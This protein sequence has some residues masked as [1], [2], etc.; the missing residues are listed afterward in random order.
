LLDQNR[1]ITPHPAF[2]LFAT[3]NTIGLG[4]TSGLYHGTQQI[5][6]GQMDRWSIVTTLNYLPHDKEAGI[7]L[8]K[9]KI[10][11]T[12]KGRKTVANMVR[13]ADL[14]RSA[15]INGDLST[16][17]SP[18]TVITWAENA[19]IFGDLGFAFRLTF[20]NKCDELERPV[21]AE[22][23]QRVFGEDLPESAANLAVT[24]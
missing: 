4:D 18:R 11:Q 21:V 24:A 10:Y 8:S 15:F 6:Q 2:R 16:V 22:F 5:N 1:V 3:T 13:L 20:L 23:Y 12:E 7:V 9:V 17:M 19:Q 14:T